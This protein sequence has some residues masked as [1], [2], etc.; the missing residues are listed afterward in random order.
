MYSGACAIL[1][2]NIAFCQKK[3]NERIYLPFY[4]ELFRYKLSVSFF[5]HERES[6]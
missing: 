3:I 4:L 6:H 2:K 5:V 1:E